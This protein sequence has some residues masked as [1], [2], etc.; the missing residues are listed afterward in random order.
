MKTAKEFEK[1]VKE[2]NITEWLGH[3][4]TLCGYQV[5]YHFIEGNVYY[6]NGCDCTNGKNLNPRT[7][8]DVAERYNMQTHPDVIKRMNN[9]WKFK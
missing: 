1:K 3:N 8:E 2:E 7:W 6:D 4:C 9:F 5:G